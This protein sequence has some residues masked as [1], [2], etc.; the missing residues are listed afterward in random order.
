MP[1][2]AESVAPQQQSKDYRQDCSNHFIALT[3]AVT[4]PPEKRSPL[5]NRAIGG[6]VCTALVRPSWALVYGVQVPCARWESQ[7]DQYTK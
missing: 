2:L 3:T 5:A 6:F 4:E 1:L 7:G